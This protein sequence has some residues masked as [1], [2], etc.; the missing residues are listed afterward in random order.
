MPLNFDPANFGDVVRRGRI[1][2]EYMTKKYKNLKPGSEAYNRVLRTD[3]YIQRYVGRRGVGP[4][5]R[6]KIPES[7]HDILDP[8]RDRAMDPFDPDFVKK[9][10]GKDSNMTLWY[11]LGGAVLVYAL[12]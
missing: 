11:I 8:N 3:P 4:Q 9:M 2:R 10:Q 7:G 1:I 5:T 12:T 6:N